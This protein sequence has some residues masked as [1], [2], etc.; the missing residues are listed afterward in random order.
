MCHR[1]RPPPIPPSDPPPIALVTI[2]AVVAIA[3]AP[4]VKMYGERRREERLGRR[5]GVMKLGCGES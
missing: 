2:A 5:G 4:R 1:D 3:V